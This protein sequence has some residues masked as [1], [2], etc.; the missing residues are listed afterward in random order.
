MELYCIECEKMVD[1]FELSVLSLHYRED[2][3]NRWSCFGEFTYSAP[4]ELP[5]DWKLS[6]EEPDADEL[7]MM[8]KAAESLELEFANGL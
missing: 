2:K 3:N 5:E 1:A 6:L 7:E 8:E 4:P